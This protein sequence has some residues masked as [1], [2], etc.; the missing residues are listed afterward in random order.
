M[1][2][3]GLIERAKQGDERAF[4]LLVHHHAQYVYNLALRLVNDPNDAEDLAQEA[5]VRTWKAIENFR[6]EASFRTWLYRIVTNLCYDRLPKLKRELVALEIDETIDLPDNYS[7]PERSLLTKELR[8]DLHSAIEELPES[9]RL[10]ITLRHLQEMSY[11]EIA[12]V[13]MQ[14]LGTVKTGIFRARQL[15]RK[16]I[17]Q[18][19]DRNG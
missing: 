4:E 18:F 6:F 16:R 14:P 11:A 7:G 9:Y 12:D 15:L 17:E 3:K 19:E 2:E 13:T 8:E 1:D 5:F 10:L